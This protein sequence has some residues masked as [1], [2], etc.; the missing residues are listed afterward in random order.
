MVGTT[1]E[2]PG[3]VVSFTIENDHKVT[4]GGWVASLEDIEP[5][6][7]KIERVR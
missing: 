6:E 1:F 3:G 2:G 5:R 4:I 7:I